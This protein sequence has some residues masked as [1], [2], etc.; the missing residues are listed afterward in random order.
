MANR[1]EQ[2][3]RLV[4][5]L[6]TAGLPVVNDFNGSDR[7]VILRVAS[8]SG[9]VSLRVFCWNVTPGGAHRAE[10]EYRVQ[11]TR[12][13]DVPLY[14]GGESLDLIL[15]YDEHRDIFVA[16]DA[17][18]HPNPG[19]S[20]SLQVQLDQL[21]EA[22]E[23]GFAA[24]T[25]ELGHDDEVEV[26]VALRPEAIGEYLEAH[27]AFGVTGRTQAEAVADAANVDTPPAEADLPG[28]I[29]RRREIVLVS[30]LVRDARFRTQVIDAYQGRCVFCGLGACLSEAAHVRA[31]AFGGDDQVQNGVAACPTHHAAFDLGLLVI[32][33]DR[34]I[35]VNPRRVEALA[36]SDEDV[37]MLQASLFEALPEPGL[38]SQRPHGANLRAHREQWS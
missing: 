6:A 1:A 5:A 21:D 14:L 35:R 9:L 33:Q 31:V 34:R 24:R 30:R 25:R 7:P 10:D 29:E 18:H 3:Q 13:G 2:I 15:G 23:R 20:S 4:N 26:V 8:P 16:W 22:A 36:I 38:T 11:T 27:H 12:P 37:E 32:E 28:D 19:G 17:S